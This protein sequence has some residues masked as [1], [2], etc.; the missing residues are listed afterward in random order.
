MI[1]LNVINTLMR[2]IAVNQPDTVYKRTLTPLPKELIVNRFPTYY[3]ILLNKE[4]DHEYNYH[5]IFT[6]DKYTRINLRFIP[7]VFP[8]KPI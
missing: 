7:N 8:K 3:S 5:N 1:K 6:R 4:S 2:E